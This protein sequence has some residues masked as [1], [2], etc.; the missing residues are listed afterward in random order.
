M[1]IFL[2]ILSGILIAVTVAQN[3]DLAVVFGNYHGTVLVHV[4]GLVTIVLWMLIRREKPSLNRKTPWPYYFGGALGVLTVVWNNLCF[5]SLG[6][7]LT[8]SLG[9]LG[10]CVAGGV[11]DHLGWF[12]MAKRR[13]QKQHLVSFALIIGGILMMLTF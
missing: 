10:Q 1:L 6:I 13:F 11:V 5:S 8:L 4:V 3:G 9:L 2:S 7:S 12:G